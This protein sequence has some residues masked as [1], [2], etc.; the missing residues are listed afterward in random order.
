MAQLRKG[1]TYATGDQIT[2]TNINALVDNAILLNGAITEQTAGTPSPTD[3][4]LVAG[5][6]DLRKVTV[7]SLLAGLVKA[8]GTVPMTADLSLANSTPSTALSAASKGYVDNRTSFTPVQQG[9]GAGQLTNKVYVG[10]GGSALNLQVDSTNFSSIWPISVSGNAATATN[11]T[12]AATAAACSGN[13]ATATLAATATN[14]INANTAAACSGNSATATLAA[15]ATNALA[16]SGNAATA[17]LAAT[18]TTA[19]NGVPAGTIVMWP[20]ATVPSGWLEC[21]GQSTAS[22]PALTSI[23]GMNVPD[24]RGYFIR[25]WDHGRG[26]D[27]SRGLLSYQA[28]EIQSHFHSVSGYVSS[29]GTSS[30]FAVLNN[31]V[32][33]PQVDTTN[34]GGTETRPVNIALMYIIKT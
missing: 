28:Q 21:N 20:T 16:C 2:A 13:S 7:S 3:N 31:A 14:A 12:N 22:Y 9:G 15:T 6:A 5:V 25:A 19:I 17:T 33:V 18:A 30:T 11:A 23:V 32:S 4:L 24:L 26:V 34:K 29:G 27:P 10:W 1:T 8:D